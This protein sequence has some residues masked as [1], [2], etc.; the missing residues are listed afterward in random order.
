V[1]PP[2]AQLNLSKK[3]LTDTVKE[4]LKYFD[5]GK[6]FTEQFNLDYCLQKYLQYKTVADALYSGKIKISELSVSY[7]EELIITWLR[8]WL[9]TL[10]NYMDFE[11]NES[12]S[13]KTAM[14]I[15][16]EC[17]MLNLA[18]L[19]LLFKRIMKGHYGHFFNKFNGQII[20]HAC[21]EY[22]KERGLIL[23]RQIL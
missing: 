18:E 8:A 4:I 3:T 7:G 23:S 15:L 19:S 9:V 17:Y 16:E 21:R 5:T 10:S 6:K 2:G 20:M 1:I 12:Q 11:I 14:F 22:R 13:K